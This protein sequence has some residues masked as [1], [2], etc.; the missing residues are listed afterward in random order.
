MAS[1]LVLEL[2]YGTELRD[3]FAQVRAG[4]ALEGN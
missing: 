1:S 2:G 3:V 4:S